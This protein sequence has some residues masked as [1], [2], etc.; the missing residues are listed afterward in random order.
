MII[1]KEKN[2]EERTIKLNEKIT[3]YFSKVKSTKNVN[4]IHDK[5]LTIGDKVAD[6]IAE[7]AGSWP[8]IICFISFLVIWIIINVSQMFTH[9]DNYPFIL[10]NLALSCVAALQAPIIM[11]SQ[12]R[13]EEIDRIRNEKDFET[14]IKS[15]VMIQEIL[16]H[17]QNIEQ[18]LDELK[19]KNKE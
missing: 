9:F 2:N 15:E 14:N 4:D 12:N 19:Q 3:E 10:L 7:V 17:V 13:H 8:F 16:N 5:T 11:M 18:Q 6:K 1:N